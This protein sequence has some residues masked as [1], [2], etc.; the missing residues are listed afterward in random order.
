[1]LADVDPATGL[2]VGQALGRLLD[3]APGAPRGGGPSAD[4]GWRALLAG[5]RAE[6]THRAVAAQL[7]AMAGRFDEAASGFL[8]AAD[9][10]QELGPDDGPAPV[11]RRQL[12]DETVLWLA[13]AGRCDEARRLAVR[14][15]PRCGEAQ[16]PGSLVRRVAAAAGTAPSRG[17]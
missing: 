8:R 6:P 12:W 7:A 3:G 1:M 2:S 17:P 14:W 9:R 4:A 13:A 16:G 5:L 11:V 10:W 15:A